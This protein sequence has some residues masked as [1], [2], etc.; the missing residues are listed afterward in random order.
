MQFQNNH[1]DSGLLAKLLNF[2]VV[3]VAVVLLLSF[4]M[5]GLFALEN[6]VKNDPHAEYYDKN[7][8][9]TVSNPKD[10][11]D[12]LYNAMGQRPYF[13]GIQKLTDLGA[14]KYHIASIEEAFYRYSGQR[15]YDIKEVSVVVDSIK[16]GSFDQQTATR[17][18]D[19][20]V[21]INRKD[22]YQA[23][24]YY[25]SIKSAK[26]ILKK[27]NKVIYQS[28]YIDTTIPEEPGD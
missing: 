22:Y 16:Y 11:T 20:D 26:I 19:F 15:N 12:E 28:D 24:V 4:I 13:L 2:K 9:E 18:I 8:G 5:F 7:S 23:S 27:D 3:L 10:R 6:K 1:Q 14:S 21:Q 25:N 17:N